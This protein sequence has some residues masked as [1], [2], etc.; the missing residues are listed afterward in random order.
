M[1][2]FVYLSDTHWGVETP[3]YTM[4][5]SHPPRLPEL[6]TALEA[7]MATYGPVDF[8]LHGGDMIDSTSE[9]H[10]D[11]VAEIFQLSV[12]V[13]LCLGNHDLTSENAAQMW[14][15]RAPHL[16]LG[17]VNFTVETPDCL[18]HVVPNQWGPEP[19]FWNGV[20]EPYFL[21]EQ[22]HFMGVELLRDTHRVHILSTHSP[23]CGV[24]PEQTGLADSFHSPPQEF[25]EQ[26]Q[27]LLE[28]H[29]S[30]RCLLGAHSHINTCIAAPTA[31]LVT[32]S[33]FV[34]VPFDFKCFEVVDGHLSMTTH[35]LVD[36]MNGTASYNYEKT[37]VQGRACDRAFGH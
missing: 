32:S 3:G 25:F 24:P 17:G 34:E 23:F 10:I 1:T 31:H 12:P 5:A 9:E 22:A 11:C 26:G 4:Q 21:P 8:V 36:Q 6:L 7:W 2:R 20:Q 15:G 14:L 37:F 33:S 29:R 28:G 30:L 18:L 13:Y 16:F 19:Y 35:S 27:A